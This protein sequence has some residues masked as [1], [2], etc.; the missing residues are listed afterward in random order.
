M[1]IPLFQ[2]EFLYSC[3]TLPWPSPLHP[4]LIARHR[5]NN[6]FISFIICTLFP[7]IH[8]SIGYHPRPLILPLSQQLISACRSSAFSFFNGIEVLFLQFLRMLLRHF[9]NNLYILLHRYIWGVIEYNPLLVSYLRWRICSL[10]R[11]TRVP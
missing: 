2:M 10:W 9:T 3:G 7:W 5:T 4:Q 11:D 8:L 6:C 1:R